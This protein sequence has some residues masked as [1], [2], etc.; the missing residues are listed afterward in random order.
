MITKFSKSLI[1]EEKFSEYLKSTPGNSSGTMNVHVGSDD[2]VKLDFGKGIV[3]DLYVKRDGGAN[4]IDL[5]TVEPNHFRVNIPAV[6]RAKEGLPLT[7][8]TVFPTTVIF[9]HADFDGD[10]DQDLIISCTGLK[11]AFLF[12]QNQDY[13]DMSIK[14]GNP[15]DF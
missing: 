10:G 15:N 3:V 13:S 8:P 11:G 14:M 9:A 5:V 4:D 1:S 12:T 2:F 7:L 6:L